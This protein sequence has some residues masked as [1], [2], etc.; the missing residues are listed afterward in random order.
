MKLNEDLASIHAYLCADGYVVKNPITQK[1][2]YYRIGFRNTNIILLKDFQ[3]K[4]ERYFG[5]KPR[6]VEGQRC[7]IGSKELYEK[8]TK[9]FGSFY[10]YKWSM[11]K[12][13]KKLNR[14][15][16]KSFFDCESWVYCKSHQNRHVSL[17]SVNKLGI[18]QIESSL[19]DLNIKCFVK[20][21]SYRN[22]YQ[23]S[24]YSKENLLKFQDKINFLHP[25][26]KEKLNLT[27]KD[28]V[29]YNWSFPSN[30]NELK[31]YL[32]KLLRKK[33]K[34]KKS[35]KIIR[36]ISN[37]E[38][39]LITLSK[40]LKKLFKIESRINKCL[41]GIGTIYYE[42]NVNKQSEIKKLISYELLDNLEKE[43]WLKLIK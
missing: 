19:I 32:F 25:L 24:I 12:L 27:I 40:E 21:K 7:E 30:T 15:W 13:T 16:L 4:F 20:L 11:P 42:L 36:V 41:N 28:F 43:K 31:K 3:D 10:S 1:Q 14:V 5:K 34:V 6:L 23:L 2:K 29:D 39:N 33:A 35:N 18:K 22:I 17:E 9:E 37:K 26:K 8:L 38:S